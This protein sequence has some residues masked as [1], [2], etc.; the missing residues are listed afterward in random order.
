MDLNNT[1]A[2]KI[3]VPRFGEFCFCCYLPLL[4]QLA[5]SILATWGPQ[6][7]R[8]LYCI[9]YRRIVV[10]EEGYGGE[11]RDLRELGGLWAPPQ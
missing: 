2:G 11:R 3:V 10:S 5:C 6:F 8:P 7:C 4:P 1:G 9:T